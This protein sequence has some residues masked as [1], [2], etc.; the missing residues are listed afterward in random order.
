MRSIFPYDPILK[1]ETFLNELL[2]GREHLSPPHQ[3]G[4]V[5]D[6]MVIEGEMEVLLNGQWKLLKKDESL[7]FPA[8]QPHGYRNQGSAIA[9]LHDIMHHPKG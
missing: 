1:V 4:M 9:R 6:V 2:P 5:E 8:D 7:R 3:K